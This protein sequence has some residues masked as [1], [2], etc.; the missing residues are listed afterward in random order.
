MRNAVKGVRRCEEIASDR[1]RWLTRLCRLLCGKPPAFRRA[2]EPKGFIGFFL[3]AGWAGKAEPFRTAGGKAA[4]F[5]HLLSARVGLK[6][7]SGY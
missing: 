5:S 7:L 3:L 1:Q 6:W 4:T 2:A